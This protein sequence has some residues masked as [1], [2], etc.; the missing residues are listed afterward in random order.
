MH[1][2]ARTRGQ[3]KNP[4]SASI[5]RAGSQEQRAMAHEQALRAGWGSQRP[6]QWSDG[7]HRHQRRGGARNVRDEHGDMRAR[8]SRST[9]GRLRTR[10]CRLDDRAATRAAKRGRARRFVL[11]RCR[12][13]AA[14]RAHLA[15]EAAQVFR[16]PAR[17][18]RWH[19]HHQREGDQD[20]TAHVPQTV[21]RALTFRKWPFR[22]SR[23]G[24]L[25]S[26]HRGRGPADRTWAARAT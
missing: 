8:A 16:S 1:P 3:A 25:A 10:R 12:G 4:A 24:V 17:R 2:S 11:L 14:R 13:A 7:R 20:D 19:E 15:V 21:C 18:D 9:L 23:P 5:R 6:P 22:A 26:G